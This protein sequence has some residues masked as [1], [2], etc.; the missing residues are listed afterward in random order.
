MDELT[1]RLLFAAVGLVAGLI[2]GWTS[3]AAHDARDVRKAVMPD[4]DTR[5]RRRLKLNRSDVVLGL[6][7]V[8]SLASSFTAWQANQRVARVSECTNV[9]TA[10][11]IE[12]VNDRTTYSEESAARNTDLQRA[13]QRMLDVFLSGADRPARVQA[14]ED[15]AVALDAFED[16]Q[17]KAAKQRRAHPYP[18]ES[19]IVQCR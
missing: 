5:P 9:V 12:A 11:I 19:E 6:L 16:I 8:I 1:V 14:L 17:T 13:Q 4:S 2:L 3:R 7:V 15:Y 10:R 18:T